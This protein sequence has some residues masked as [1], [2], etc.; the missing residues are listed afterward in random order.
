MCFPGY[1]G[2]TGGGQTRKYKVRWFKLELCS[3]E[4]I[5]KVWE[6]YVCQDWVAGGQT[7]SKPRWLPGQTESF[8]TAALLP[9]PFYFTASSK[10][11]YL[12][13][14]LAST[15]H[16][17]FALSTLPLGRSALHWDLQHSYDFWFVKKTSL[18]KL[19]LFN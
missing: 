19:Y 18:L 14:L 16:K 2:Y 9:L 6:K 3:L 17:L 13:L 7:E 4:T 15:A 11:D 1:K 10:A 8:S 5:V 12:L